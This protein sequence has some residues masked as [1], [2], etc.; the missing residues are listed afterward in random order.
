[1][2]VIISWWWGGIGNGSFITMYLI[3]VV[4]SRLSSRLLNWWHHHSNHRS[5]YIAAY[6]CIILCWIMCFVFVRDSI[7]QRKTNHDVL[8]SSFAA[9][10]GRFFILN[11]HK[12]FLDVWHSI[13]PM[14]YLHNTLD[15]KG[16]QDKEFPCF[17]TD[18]FKTVTHL[19]T[20]KD[21]SH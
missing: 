11:S 10:C 19:C 8:Q 18:L 4:M 6:I 12:Q 3:F 9:W 16:Q 5:V 21:N 1:M 15:E 13:K 2:A 20:I 14:S 17:G 7:M